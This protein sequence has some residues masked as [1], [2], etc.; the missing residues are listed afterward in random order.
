MCASALRQYGLRAVYY[1]CTNDKFGGTGGVLN[2]HDDPSVDKPLQVFSGICKDEAILLLRKFY[3]QE[4]HNA[5]EPNKKKDRVLKAEI[6][7]R[8]S[9][10]S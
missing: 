7:D 10:A 5:P 1:G 9:N 6:L 2:I 4:N 3:L 8:Q